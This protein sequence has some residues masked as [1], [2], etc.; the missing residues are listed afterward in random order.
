[1]PPSQVSKV[2]VCGATSLLNLDQQID[3]LQAGN[4]RSTLKGSGVLARPSEESA[5]ILMPIAHCRQRNSESLILVVRGSWEA[6]LVG[7]A[8]AC[9]QRAR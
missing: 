9:F 4:E 2:S 8:D 1:M 3:P 6:S 7:P 5:S